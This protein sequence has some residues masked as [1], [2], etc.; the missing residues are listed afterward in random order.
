MASHSPTLREPSSPALISTGSAGLQ[1]QLTVDQ[2]RVAEVLGGTSRHETLV[3]GLH[4][5]HINDNPQDREVFA[6]CPSCQMD[7]FDSGLTN[8]IL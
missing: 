5:F 2:I 8:E 1:A 6:V 4:G 7:V 3:L